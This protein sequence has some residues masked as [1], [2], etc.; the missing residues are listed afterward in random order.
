MTGADNS[1]IFRNHFEPEIG[2]GIEI[3]KRKNIE[4]FEN[5]F[6]IESAPPSCEYGHEDY[7]TNGI[8]LADYNAKPGAEDGCYGNKIYD[9]KFYITGKDYPEYVDYKPVATAF[10]YSASAGDNYIFNNEIEI[11]ALNPKSKAETVAFYVGGGT[12]GG[13]FTDNTITTNVPAFWIASMY[14]SATGCKV[15]KNNIIKSANASST[16]VPIRLGFY[17]YLAKN[18]EFRSNNIEQG[19]LKFGCT[20]ALHTYSVFWTLTVNVADT[21]ENPAEGVNVQIINKK[22]TVVYTGETPDSG[23][24][25]VELEEYSLQNGL[26][27]ELSPYRVIADDEEV[28]VT[29]NKN[30]SI[31]IISDNVTGTGN[32]KNS[33]KF[34]FGPNPVKSKLNIDFGKSSEREISIL[35]FNSNVQSKIISGDESIVLDLS[36][37]S[38]GIYFLNVAEDGQ[39]FTEKLIK[40]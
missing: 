23:R 36:F 10:F 25:T 28:E 9:N 5:E 2:S 12:I 35:D 16:Y 8:R 18:I 3:Y 37:L 33:G 32:I 38:S 1:K 19:E 40:R 39:A 6:H 17:N 30:T 34:I 20:S 7:S 14:G 29:L 31:N 24:I 22:G 15:S 21:L 13:E 11:N 26:K 4:I 27:D